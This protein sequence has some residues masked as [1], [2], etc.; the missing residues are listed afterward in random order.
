MGGT[1]RSYEITKYLKE[2]GFD[3]SVFTPKVPKKYIL[4][5][6]DD[7]V[8]VK[9]IYSF[10]PFH[11]PLTPLEG[12]KGKRD[13]ISFP[14]NKIGFLPFLINNLEESDIF[15]TSSPPVSVHIAGLFLKKR[16]YRWIAEFRDPYT[17][18]PIGKYLLPFQNELA[19]SLERIIIEKADAVVTLSYGLENEFKKRYSSM[20]ITTITNGYNESDFGIIQEEKENKFILTYLG[21]IN[22]THR[23][24]NIIKALEILQDR[25]KN[26]KDIFL[27]KVIGYIIPEY[28]EQL[29]LFPF[30]KYE[31]YLPRK[32][33]IRK[34]F[35][36][37]LLLLILTDEESRFAIPGKTFNYL[38]SGKNILLVSGEGTLKDFLKDYA[39]TSNNNPEEIASKIEMSLKDSMKLKKF[40]DIQR[41]EW[42]NI[43]ERYK[44]LILECV[45]N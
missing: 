37:D 9:R 29:S 7:V 11:L 40:P 27:F 19:R 22:K 1:E 5:E 43:G 23:P 20:K 26:L 31:G 18:G 30:F 25:I 13:F 39:I 36:S 3:V 33:A 35:S 24:D 6:V 21:T 14:D 45:K 28:L 41:Y 16:G 34:M 8:N 10:D 4:K 12:G 32:E 17:D 42:K 15:I 2:N 38:R 44:N